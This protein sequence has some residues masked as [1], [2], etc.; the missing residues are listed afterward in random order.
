MTGDGLFQSKEGRKRVKT[1][2]LMKWN[3]RRIFRIDR[4]RVANVPSTQISQ[5]RPFNR[6]TFG[7]LGNPT[8]P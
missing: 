8:L 5:K 4:Q 2:F 6:R 7:S 3:P 1:K